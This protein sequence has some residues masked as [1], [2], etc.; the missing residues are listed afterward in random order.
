MHESNFIKF[1]FITPAI[2]A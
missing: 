2:G 1:L